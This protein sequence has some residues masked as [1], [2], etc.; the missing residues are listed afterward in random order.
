MC[1][2]EWPYRNLWLKSFNHASLK[3][4]EILEYRKKDGAFSYLLTS[5]IL[6]RS[7]VF[8]NSKLSLSS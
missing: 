4:A 2:A 5:V 1:C 7:L 3:S 6:T 8:A